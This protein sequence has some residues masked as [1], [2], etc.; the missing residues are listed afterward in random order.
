MMTRTTILEKIIAHKHREVEACK[1]A[2]PEQELADIVQDMPPPKSLAKAIRGKDQLS[3]IAEMKRASPSA[4]LLRRNF[5]PVAIARSYAKAGA[6]AISVLTDAHFFQGRL[7]HIRQIR[8]LVDMPILRKDF[9]IDRYQL[10]EARAA[11]ADAVLLIVAALE[12]NVLAVLLRKTHGLGIDALVEVHTEK[13]LDAALRVGAEIIGINNR[14]LESFEIDLATTENLVPKSPSG[15]VIVG[16]SGIT[17]PDDLARMR[18]SGVDAALVGS[19]FMRES[20][21]GE[22]LA[23]FKKMCG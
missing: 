7:D 17:T 10:L 23:A 1:L 19:H 5:E 8:P 4:G 13:E 18:K 16:E 12:E 11:G 6:D 22:A 3:V 21:P 20:N 14:N 2:T 15:K 9:I